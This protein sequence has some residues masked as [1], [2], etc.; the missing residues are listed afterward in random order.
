MIGSTHIRYRPIF[1]MLLAIGFFVSIIG[2]DES[3]AGDELLPLNGV[4]I[5]QFLTDKTAFYEDGAKQYFSNAVWT[6]YVAT[7][8]PPDRGKWEVR[9]DQYCSWWERG[10]WAC[11]DVVGSVD[12]TLITWIAPSSGTQYPATMV[13]GHKLN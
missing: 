10:G 2:I 4:E 6:D 8:G 7:S 13:D 5:E 9:G 3:E 11:Y 1:A 12:G